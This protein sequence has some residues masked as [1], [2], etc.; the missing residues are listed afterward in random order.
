MRTDCIILGGGAAGLAAC[1]ALANSGIQTVVI[2]KSDRIGRKIM[3]AG[4]GRCNISNADMDASYYGHAASFVRSVYEKTPPDE[5]ARFFSSLGLMTAQEEGR[6][7]PRTMMAS[8]VLDVLRAGCTA[9]NVSIMTGCE[10]VSITPSRRAGWSIQL[11]SG[12]GLFAP[13]VLVAMGG[14]AGPHLGTDGAGTRLLAS[15]G[16][17]ITPL[18][19]ALVQLKCDHPALRSLKGV[20]MQ[21]RLTLHIDGRPAAQ[22]TGELLFADYGV[23]G[24]CVFQLSRHAAR[25][26]AEKRRVSLSVKLLPE[27]EDI[28]S[29]LDARIHMLAAADAHSLFTGVFPRLLSQALLRQAGIAQDSAPSQFDA[30]ARR[31]LCDAIAA[32]PLPVTGTQGFKS[33]QV[34]AGGI[35]LDE[36]DPSSMASRLWNGLYLAGEV[37]DV[38]GPCGGYNLHFAFASGLTAAKA[39]I[40]QLR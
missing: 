18:C 31:A 11:Q 36:A 26:L 10:A 21:A 1:A 22:E 23:S 27:I 25:A 28:S 15:L 34:T 17:S 3:A 5:V 40:E 20:R 8:S 24:V 35:S 32:F 2:E 9:P 7:Y 6:I 12:E 33:A 30:S 16:H 39:I 29:W 14:S 13:A 38:D 4:N 37:L 19:P